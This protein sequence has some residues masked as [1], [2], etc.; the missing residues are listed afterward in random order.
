MLNLSALEAIFS[1]KLWP[2]TLKDGRIVAIAFPRRGFAFRGK[3]IASVLKEACPLQ[4]ISFRSSSETFYDRGP[5]R[6]PPPIYR[7]FKLEVSEVTYPLYCLEILPQDPAS[8]DHQS[9]HMNNALEIDMHNLTSTGVGC[10][11]RTW[12]LHRHETRMCERWT[13]VVRLMLLEAVKGERFCGL[14][15]PGGLDRLPHTSVST[16]CCLS[17]YL[18]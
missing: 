9:R 10:Q 12:H 15:L 14:S 8:R 16:L 6:V 13:C 7:F 2:N 18:N 4:L 11:V 5:L 3:A 17:K 1:S